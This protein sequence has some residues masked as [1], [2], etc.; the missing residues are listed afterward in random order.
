MKYFSSQNVIFFDR[1]S[2]DCLLSDNKFVKIYNFF[3]VNNYKLTEIEDE[4]NVIILD[5]CWVNS[6]FLD[7]TKYKIEYYLN[8]WKQI[9]LIGC[10]SEIFRKNYWEKIIY[11]DSKSYIDVEKYFEFKIWITKIWDYFH[12]WKINILD[13]DN[14]FKKYDSE[15]ANFEKIAFIEISDWCSLNC[16]YC[17]IKKIKGD[18]KS[19]KLEEVIEQIKLEVLKWKTEIFLLSD[20]CGS[21]WLDIWTN[22]WKLVKEI[23]KLFDNIRL[24]ITNIYPSYLVKY[25]DDIKNYIYDNK[26]PYILIPMQHY[27]Y[28]ILK[29]MNRS[30]DV[31]KI[32]E[33]LAD[34]KK[35][36]NTNLCNHIIFNY[37][38][39][40]LEEFVET[41]KYL[42]Y[43]NRTFYFKYSDVNKIY[44]SN[45][46][47][48]D[49]DKKFIL[50]KKLQKKYTIDIT[51]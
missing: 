4:S 21:Y 46:I 3:I 16:S 40:T 43:Y 5:L 7:S 25:Y 9:I 11:I 49:L 51:I 41:F 44:L 47:S 10:I 48:Y 19:L 33:I 42:Q 31:K 24:H 38:E 14:S 1:V 35:E 36:S 27:S 18:T 2:I 29:L 15:L 34:I 45:H 12:N 17:N 20:D 32:I 37:H 30:Y 28:R 26:I 6:E 39:E 22:F 23:F 8:K 50:L 13:T